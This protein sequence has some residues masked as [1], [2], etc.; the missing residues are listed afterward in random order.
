MPFNATHHETVLG[1]EF[2]LVV[3]LKKPPSIIT[4]SPTMLERVKASANDPDIFVDLHTPGIAIAM[5]AGKVLR[6]TIQDMTF[7][8]D[9]TS[10]VTLVEDVALRFRLAVQITEESD[11]EFVIQTT[12]GTDEV[13][14]CLV[15]SLVYAN[16]KLE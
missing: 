13:S 16:T 1:R 3:H 14:N 11:R 15:L 4:L 12:V 10:K 7:A 5:A 2:F 6:V 8:L 9:C